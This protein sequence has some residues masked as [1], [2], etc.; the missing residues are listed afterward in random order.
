M[1]E[2]TK[3][4]M[5]RALSANFSTHSLSD[6]VISADAGV[7]T[8]APPP[9]RWVVGI[10]D[11]IPFC[12]SWWCLGRKR[13]NLL[14]TPYESSWISTRGVEWWKKQNE[15]LSSVFAFLEKWMCEAEEDDEVASPHCAVL[16]H[17]GLRRAA[18][19]PGIPAKNKPGVGEE[20]RRE[21]SGFLPLS[22]LTSLP[23]TASPPAPPTA[24]RLWDSFTWSLS[25][26]AW[27]ASET[28]CSVLNIFGS[29][30]WFVSLILFSFSCCFLLQLFPSCVTVPQPSDSL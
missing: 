6:R 10:L 17:A 19:S 3:K 24:G 28:H 5:R 4:S 16:V 18:W 2:V 13:Q 11:E 25:C 22:C 30:W 20:R 8:H 7:D 14:P 12:S 26:T 29:R 1:W 9:A 27:C 21:R 23:S 15:V